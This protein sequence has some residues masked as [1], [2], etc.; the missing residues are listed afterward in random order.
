CKRPMVASMGARSRMLDIRSPKGD[1]RHRRAGGQ[2]VLVDFRTLENHLAA[3]RDGDL[4]AAVD[5]D[6]GAIDRDVAT[7]LHDD[8]RTAALQHQLA[9]G[10][11]G[12]LGT[13]GDAVVAAG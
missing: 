6:L 7:A 4:A 5:S 1:C 11:N 13:A 3:R 2:S 10:R 12:D 8:L 9:G